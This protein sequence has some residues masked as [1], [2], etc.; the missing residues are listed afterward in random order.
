MRHCHNGVAG[1]RNNVTGVTCVRR[2]VDLL[3][4]FSFLRRLFDAP[5]AIATGKNVTAVT[6]LRHSIGSDPASP[7][8]IVG[9]VYTGVRSSG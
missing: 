5:Q 8:R 3:Y 9:G 4:S 1:R 2:N 6:L 7:R